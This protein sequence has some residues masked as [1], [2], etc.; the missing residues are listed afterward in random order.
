MG[1]KKVF[2]TLIVTGFLL[3]MLMALAFPAHVDTETLYQIGD[4]RIMRHGTRDYLVYKNKGGKTN[5]I[6][7]DALKYAE[8]TID[9]N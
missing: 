5:S 2:C 8:F 9:P 4:V 6:S 1:I 3:C 7:L